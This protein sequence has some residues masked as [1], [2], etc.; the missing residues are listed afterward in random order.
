ML[1]ELERQLQLVRM[2]APEMV[3]AQKAQW[4]RDHSGADV[5][6][7]DFEIK[8]LCPEKYGLQTH[9]EIKPMTAREISKKNRAAR[10]A[11]EDGAELQ[12]REVSPEAEPAQW[13]DCSTQVDPD[14][15]T[16]LLEWRVK[17]KPRE[18]WL[19]ICCGTGGGL[20]FLSGLS[21][22]LP[23]IASRWCQEHPRGEVVH[24]REVLE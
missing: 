22:L 23:K 8:C 12:N 9:H 14:W 4:L 24:V 5:V 17:P 3:R 1:A 18:W 20:S 19:G 2:F 11:W 10:E 16:R 13:R 7:G 15:G 21:F 6:I